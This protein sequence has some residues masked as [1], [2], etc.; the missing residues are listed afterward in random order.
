MKSLKEQE[1]KTIEN[2]NTMAQKEKFAISYIN[3]FSNLEQSLQQNYNINIKEDIQ[4]FLSLSMIL[5]KKAMM[6]R[7]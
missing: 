2:L 7:L 1:S 3:W 6:L 4:S 5:N